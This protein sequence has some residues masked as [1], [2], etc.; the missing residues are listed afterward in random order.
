MAAATTVTRML[1]RL[2]VTVVDMASSLRGVSGGTHPPGGRVPRRLAGAPHGEWALPSGHAPWEAPTRPGYV[3]CGAVL[4]APVPLGA[5]ERVAGWSSGVRFA[6]G[7][8]VGGLEATVV[9]R[10]RR[11]GAVRGPESSHQG[12]P[13]GKWLLSSVHA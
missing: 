13:H 8:V 3:A 10:C 7:G 5:G 1:R 6:C 11:Q 4:P 9:A 12:P 2:T